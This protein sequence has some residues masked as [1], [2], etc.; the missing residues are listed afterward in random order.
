ML[1]VLRAARTVALRAIYNLDNRIPT[2]RAGYIGNL[3]LKS[4]NS[5]VA[6]FVTLLILE[7]PVR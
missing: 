7:S 6:K 3:Q 2:A 4:H 1:L 5:E